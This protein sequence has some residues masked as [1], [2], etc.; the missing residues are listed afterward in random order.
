[1][2][3]DGKVY[4][5]AQERTPLNY[6][7][8]VK[9]KRSKSLLYY[10]EAKNEQRALRYAPNQRS[11]FVDEQDD[12]ARLGLIIFKDGTLFVGNREPLLHTFLEHHPGNTA[13]G[14]GSF[15]E[16][17]H[18]AEHERVIE[19]M[20]FEFEAQQIAREMSVNDMV[21]LMRKIKP[22]EVD[23]METSEIKRDTKVFARNDPHKFMSLVE[24][25]SGDDSVMNTI[26]EA[27]DEKIIQLRPAK[28]EVYWMLE[29]K[30]SRMFKAPEGEDLDVA[31]VTYLMSNEGLGD[32]KEIQGYLS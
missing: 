30:K 14:G 20:D 10:D 7:L 9:D 27:V 25:T 13:N 8:Q 15:F 28:R 2:K 6:M 11:I 4:R 31:F 22:H 24:V 29:E 3:R 5:L 26:A 12:N 19:A 1:M 32:Y 18:E 21:T 16:V 23:K 17:N